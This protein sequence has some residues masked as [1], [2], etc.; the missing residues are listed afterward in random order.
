MFARALGLSCVC[1]FVCVCVAKK[2]IIL[3]LNV[4]TGYKDG[5]SVHHDAVEFK[6]IE[7][8]VRGDN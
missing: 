2:F 5:G 7:C 1:A 8:L 3:F 4:K 6:L